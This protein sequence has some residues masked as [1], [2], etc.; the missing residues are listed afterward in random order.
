MPDE[1]VANLFRREVADAM[2]LQAVEQPLPVDRERG[3]L[4]VARLEPVE[5]TLAEE[6]ERLVESFLPSSFSPDG[7][8]RHLEVEEAGE[9]RI[10]DG[11]HPLLVVCRLEFPASRLHLLPEKFGIADSLEVAYGLARQESAV[12]RGLREPRVR[13]DP[14]QELEELI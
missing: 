6:R 11:D 8:V 9:Q 12:A 1:V 3:L 13:L 7:P 4:A 10:E 5:Q 14:V 2:D